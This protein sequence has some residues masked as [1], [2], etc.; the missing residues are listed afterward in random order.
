[1]KIT[2]RS[3]LK[4]IPGLVAIPFLPKIAA[5]L[6]DIPVTVLESE[7]DA[8][9]AKIISKRGV[10]TLEDAARLDQLFRVADEMLCRRAEKKFAKVSQTTNDSLR[11]VQF[12]NGYIVPEGGCASYDE[13]SRSA[14]PCISKIQDTWLAGFEGWVEKNGGPRG[15]ELVWREKPN[16]A[17]NIDFDGRVAKVAIWGRAAIR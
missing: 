17:M 4:L 1:M 5:A 13:N 7:L 9:I 14:K 16:L 8:L 15:R 12:A 11:P 2:R 6:P 10:T 3:I